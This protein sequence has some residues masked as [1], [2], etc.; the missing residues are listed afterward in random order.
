MAEQQPDT[1]TLASAPLSS[2]S[3]AGRRPRRLRR[4]VAL[5]VL[6]ALLALGLPYGL[7]LWHYY[8]THETTDDAFVVGTIV[9]V[10]PRVS[11]TVLEVFVDDHQQVEAGQVL[12]R[13]DPRDFAVRVQQ[14]EAAVAVARAR[15]QQ[16][17]QEVQLA[18]DSTRSDTA[19]AEAMVRAARAALQEAQHAATEA[20]ARLRTLEA[21]VAAARAEGEAARARLEMARTAF[22]RLEQLLAAGVVPQQQ[23]DEA[24]ATLDA[25]AARWRASQ[26]QL[27]QAQ[28]EVER[29]RVD[30]QMRQQAVVRARA[31]VAEMQALH[32][33]TQAR[34]QDVAV[35]RAQAEMAR[36]LL[37]QAQADLEEARLQLAYTTLRA[38]L[39][40]VV[41]K[42][43]LEVGQV[44]QAG[45]PVLAIVPLD[46]VWV[47]AN[48]KETQLTHMRPGQKATLKVDAYPGH[49]FTGTVASISP[50]TGAV[51]SLLPP[52]NATGNFVKVVQRVP[53][54]IVLDDSP[55][56]EPV[57][58]PGMSVVVTVAIHSP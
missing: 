46:D 42:K 11:G 57:L 31:Q 53:V 6:A 4:L 50:G 41:A 9:P 19:R 30:V 55:A 43:N 3:V 37:Q 1:A 48:F 52:E 51:F 15:L 29:A 7:R 2:G 10:S 33:G 56:R 58:R 21:A 27:R 26:E 16:A 24:K 45:R 17:E 20:Q 28:H 44:V 25:A 35:K 23:V 13:L 54:K 14:A 40:G 22:A 38:P 32:R 36:A 39:A 49:V 12:A 34:Q 5:G 18:Q 8:Q 47:E